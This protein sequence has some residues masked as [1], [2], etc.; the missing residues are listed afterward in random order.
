MALL[1]AVDYSKFQGAVT[2]SSHR[3]MV[4]AGIEAV[5]VG[6]WHGHDANRYA[7]ASL[8]NAREVGLL[9]GGYIVLNERPGREAVQRGMAVAGAHWSSLF[10]VA[11]DVEVAGVTEDTYREAEE[12]VRRL[13]QRPF[14]YT[15]NWFIDAW[16]EELGSP[17][18]LGR[19]DT[20]LAYYNDEPNLQVPPRPTYGNII[21][22]QYRG[23]TNAFGTTVDFN[24]F[25]EA[26][27][28]KETSMD[29]AEFNELF[30][31]AVIQARFPGR[32]GH[33]RTGVNHTLAEWAYKLNEHLDNHPGAPHSHDFTLEIPGTAH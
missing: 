9:R 18:D 16:R 26:W 12:E 17:P 14:L 25:D 32:L 7:Q 4:S 10:G 1:Q 2:L 23:S 22:H 6:L 11:L 21:G 13:G 3:Q 15:A 8:D 31:Q 27:L 30:K 20:W 19:P 5:V 33:N 24:V 29:Q 28:R